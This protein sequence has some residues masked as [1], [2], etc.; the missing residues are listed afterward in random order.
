MRGSIMPGL[1]TIGV[2]SICAEDVAVDVD[3]RRH[4]DQLH[5]VAAAPEHAALGHVEHRLS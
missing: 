5:A 3:A 4:L 2:N 1:R